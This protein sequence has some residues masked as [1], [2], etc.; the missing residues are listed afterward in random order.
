MLPAIVMIGC[1]C[2]VNEGTP[3]RALGFPDQMHL[4]LMGETVALSRIAGNAGTNNV[5]PGRLAS[6][7]PWKYVIEIEITAIQGFSAI[8]TGV[9][10]AFED[11]VAGELHLLLREAFEEQ[12]DNDARNPDVDRNRF[13]HFRFR[14]KTGEILPTIE[15]VGE[16]ISFFVRGDHLGVPLVEEGEGPTYGTRIDR[17]PK[18]VENQNRLI[19]DRIHRDGVFIPWP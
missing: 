4:R 11:V 9:F 15:I 18:A 8:L 1:K 5:F 6:A 16:E 3:F 14:I 7:V 13:D 2:D 19:K 10:I 17:L 12:E